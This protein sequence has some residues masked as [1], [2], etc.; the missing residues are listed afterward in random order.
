M[1]ASLSEF[2]DIRRTSYMA[3]ICS[4]DYAT[5]LFS[6]A[7]AAALMLYAL[8]LPIWTGLA[9]IGC[10]L[11]LIWFLPQQ[12][13]RASCKTTCVPGLS[14]PNTETSPLLSNASETS[15]ST[16][17]RT[18]TASKGPGLSDLARRYC[19]LVRSSRQTQWLF[20][21][22]FLTG[23]ANAS[24]SLLSLYIPKRYDVS[25]SQVSNEIASSLC[26]SD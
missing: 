16:Q 26:C 12:A 10:A 2:A 14:N 18:K 1:I 17:P 25:F 19:S 24:N 8:W 11:P 6:P 13:G 22:F 5:S 3:W 4:I 23:F 15:T 21:T 9:L 20:L 7:L